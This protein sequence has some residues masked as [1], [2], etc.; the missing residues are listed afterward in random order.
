M[1]QINTAF[2]SQ[3]SVN[4]AVRESAAD[5]GVSIL[6]FWPT[7]FSQHAGGRFPSSYMTWDTETSGFSRDNDVIIEFGSCLVQAGEV[8]D[9]SNVVL[10]WFKS[11]NIPADYIRSQLQRVAQAMRVQNKGWRVTEDVMRQEGI[12][13][14]QALEWMY[15]LFTLAKEKNILL[16]SHNGIN[17]D[18]EMLC[19]SFAQDLGKEF[20]FDPDLTWD[21]SAIEKASQLI[22][23]PASRPKP[24]ETL[25][26]YF[27]RMNSWRVK[28]VYTNLSDHCVKRYRLQEK[29]GIDPASMHS[30]G[31]DA[32]VLHLLMQEFALASQRHLLAMQKPAVPTSGVQYRGQRNR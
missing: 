19:S 28:G 27:K 7:W 25:Q 26:A 10:N 9:R 18:Q 4:A 24:G 22:H 3:Q 1:G 5:V 13:P 29:Y 16:V 12:D 11:P 2:K 31:T 32:Y 15:S 8:I 6:T 14:I 17:F 23:E 20:E 21:T 30:A